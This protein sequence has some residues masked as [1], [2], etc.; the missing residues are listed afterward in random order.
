MPTGVRHAERSGREGTGPAVSDAPDPLGKRALYWAPA[1]ARRGGP[2]RAAEGDV[3]G[4]HALYSA[5]ARA[6]A[7]AVAPPLAPPDAAP[8]RAG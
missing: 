8:A 6:S 2:R 5:E 3:P 4:K 1:R 7:G